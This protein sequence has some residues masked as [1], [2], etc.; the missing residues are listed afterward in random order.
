MIVAGTNLLLY[1][2]VPGDRTELAEATLAE[3]PAWAAPPL[4][5]REFRN[6]LAGCDR[7]GALDA[8]Q[9]RTVIAEAEL[10]MQG[11]EHPVGS[12]E[13]LDLVARSACSEYD[14]EFVAVAVRL[15]VPLATTDGN[16]LR[17]FPG[18][19]VSLVEFAG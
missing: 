2:L 6:V 17:E 13:V 16:V 10:L 4:W 12:R 15:G 19:A 9:L 18:I 8:S 7:R 3:G 5:L 1:L 14:C 11:R